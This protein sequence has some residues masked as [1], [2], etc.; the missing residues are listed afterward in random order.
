MERQALLYLSSKM[1][2]TRKKMAGTG[3]IVIGEVKK[4]QKPLLINCWKR[5]QEIRKRQLLRRIERIPLLIEISIW[6]KDDESL[7][8]TMLSC[9]AYNMFAL[10]ECMILTSG[11]A[12]NWKDS[13]S[14]N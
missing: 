6:D 2:M 14:D 9:R 12:S 13:F 4:F 10:I 11:T 1:D 3:G 8:K 5:R 7:Q